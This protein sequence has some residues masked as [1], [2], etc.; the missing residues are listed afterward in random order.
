VIVIVLSAMLTGIAWN[1]QNQND[2][3][4]TLFI[5]IDHDH[6]LHAGR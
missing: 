2:T 1:D 3:P 5:L 6:R 4:V